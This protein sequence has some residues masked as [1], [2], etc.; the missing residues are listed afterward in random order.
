MNPTSAIPVNTYLQAD[1]ANQAPVQ[2]TQPS[3]PTQ[4]GS[5]PSWLEKLLPTA[6]G[7]LGG[8]AGGA[9]DVASL[10]ALAPLINP[11][12]GAAAGGALGKAGE[13]AATG[14]SL[15]GGVLG[16]AIEN[17]VGQGAGGLLGKGLQIGSGA[18]SDL[19]SKGASK[20]FAA[21][22]PGIGEDLANFATQHLGIN[23]LPTAAKFGEVISGSTDPL[24]NADKGL[25]SKFVEDAAKQDNSTV[26]LSNLQ[27]ATKG[28]SKAAQISQSS[29]KIRNVGAPDSN[30]TEQ[31]ISNNGL[32]GTNEADGLRS[33]IGGVLGRVANPG[34]VSKSDLLGMQKQIAS[35][36][37]DASDAAATS[38]ASVDAAKAK[39]LNGVN[40]QLK[41]SLGF[42]TM[43]VS[44]EDAQA[45][46]DDIKTNG[47]GI[48]KTGAA[49]VAKDITDAANS[50]EGLTVGQVRNMESN[51]VQLQ[52]TAK[53]AITSKDKNF[54][55]STSNILP[56]A[57]SIAG[58]GGKKSVLGTVA[59]L[60]TSSSKADAA[61]SGLSSALSKVTGKAASSKIIPLLA[62]TAAVSAAN[63]PNDTGEAPLNAGSGTI[64]TGASTM[65][66]NVMS[67][68][69]QSP[70]MQAYQT[71]LTGGMG[72]GSPYTS[73]LT[74]LSPEVQKIEQ[75]APIIQQLLSGYQ[76]AG[77]AQGP[78]SG[79]LTR[80]SGLVPGTAANQYNKDQGTTQAI[81]AQ[82]LG[83]NAAQYAG[84]TPQLTSSPTTAG[85]PMSTISGL[86]G[87]TQ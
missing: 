12:T 54:G 3:T 34:S 63:L 46:A 84:A 10:G 31:L 38:R 6:G 81:L 41:T 48:S 29:A 25:A 32:N 78:L 52:Q 45:L 28:G 62:R 33:Q 16:S 24:S 21:Q 49:A 55:T 66:P 65:Q 64:N 15:G 57:G 74:T 7:I 43:K 76:A 14:K 70:I 26:D 69:T 60:A 80:L 68:L 82:L 20:L 36:A 1:E 9:A 71:A 73:A 8:I 19:A 58:I 61:A 4:T 56:V 44:P 47:S 39:V 50:D 30:I 87:F 27:P 51:M 83:G 79:A 42:D 35:M 18:V 11:I 2:S 13:N 75:A 22:G 85:S 72:I 40:Q 53:D 37:S 17:G 77:G 59:G 67:S 23:D 5:Q 86:L